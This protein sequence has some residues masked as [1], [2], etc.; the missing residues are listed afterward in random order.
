MLEQGVRNPEYGADKFGFTDLEA[1]NLN[2]LELE[3]YDAHLPAERPSS[4]PEARSAPRRAYTPAAVLLR[5]LIAKHN[6][7]C[8]LVNTGWTGG[9][10]G[11]G[12]RMPINVTR[13]LLTAALNGTTLCR[14]RQEMR[15]SQRECRIRLGLA[16]KTSRSS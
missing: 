4:R 15:A 13:T 6:V 10:Y 2:L 9:K 11:F 8:W 7:N 1:V 5:S 3:L 16:A 14:I 12:Q